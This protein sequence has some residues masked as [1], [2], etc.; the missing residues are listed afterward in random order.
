MQCRFHGGFGDLE[1][2]GDLSRRLRGPAATQA[3]GLPDNT[4]LQVEGQV[5]PL[6]GQPNYRMIPTLEATKVTRIDTPANP[7]DYPH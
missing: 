3:A 7:Y 6:A 2:V 4:W 5:R 1:I